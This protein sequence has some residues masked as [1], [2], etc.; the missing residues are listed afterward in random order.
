MCIRVSQDERPFSVLPFALLVHWCY[1]VTIHFCSTKMA[2]GYLLEAKATEEEWLLAP[3]SS[4]P[5]TVPHVHGDD[6][7]GY[8]MYLFL[9]PYATTWLTDECYCC[10]I[11]CG[12]MIV[13][14]FLSNAF[15]VCNF[16]K[17]KSECTFNFTCCSRQ[18]M[19]RY[20]YC[21]VHCEMWK[22]RMCIQV[23]WR[24]YQQLPYQESHPFHSLSCAFCGYT[25]SV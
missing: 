7:S 14:V 8:V 22:W 17:E 4:S 13:G 16:W 20:I 19:Y 25:D 1:V 15:V 5:W 9:D 18:V 21:F 3:C 11:V 10:Q 6:T 2:D 12:E 24:E 23:L